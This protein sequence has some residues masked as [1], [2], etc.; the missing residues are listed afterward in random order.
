MVVWCTQNAPRLTLSGSRFLWHQPCQCCK[1]TTLVDIQKRHIKSYH[2]CRITCTCSE[3]AWEWRTALYKSNHH[4][5]HLTKK[6]L[7]TVN[8]LHSSQQT[9]KIVR[10]NFSFLWSVLFMWTFLDKIIAPACELTRK[11]LRLFMLAT[12]HTCKKISPTIIC[13]AGQAVKMLLLQKHTFHKTSTTKWTTVQAERCLPGEWQS[14][15]LLQRK[16]DCLLPVS[17]PC[18]EMI[19]SYVPCRASFAPRFHMHEEQTAPLIV[20]IF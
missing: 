20:F 2:S 14:W 16:A 18:R 7:S 15:H 13:F 8:Y 9:G 17:F 11:L 3:S 1:Y 5:H 4:H 10:P 6:L 12:Q 19:Q